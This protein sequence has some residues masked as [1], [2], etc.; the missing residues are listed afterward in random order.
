MLSGILYNTSNPT[1][2]W[3][4]IVYLSSKMDWTTWSSLGR[5]YKNEKGLA[6]DHYKDWSYYIMDPSQT[7]Q[8]IGLEANAG[9]TVTISH[10]PANYNF[11]F[12]VV[13]CR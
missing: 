4:A 7:S 1:D 9:K 2:K 3:Q 13:K 8:I 12:Q 11:G 6:G 10:M 5:D